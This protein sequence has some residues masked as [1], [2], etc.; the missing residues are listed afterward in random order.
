M[1]GNDSRRLGRQQQQQLYCYITSLT[2]FR[3]LEPIGILLPL[4]MRDATVSIA[5]NHSCLKSELT[6]MKGDTI[7]IITIIIIVGTMYLSSA[8]SAQNILSTTFVSCK[9]RM[10]NTFGFGLSVFLT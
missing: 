3:L 5:D 10:K 2:T 1:D 4:L 6:I 9:P 7:I 8:V